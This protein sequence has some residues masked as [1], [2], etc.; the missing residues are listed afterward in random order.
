MP[1]R[2]YYFLLRWN[3]FYTVWLA[4]DCHLNGRYVYPWLYI[5]SIKTNQRVI[6]LGGWNRFLHTYIHTYT[7]TKEHTWN[8]QK[9][10]ESGYCIPYCPHYS[11]FRRMRLVCCWMSQALCVARNDVEPEPLWKEE[12]KQNETICISR[13]F[14]N[15]GVET[16]NN[17]YMIG[18]ARKTEM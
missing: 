10:H 1:A 7:Q 11:Q 6:Q 2:W 15:V 12:E 17:Y 18:T 4:D 3:S 13:F 9:I 5:T 16:W 14:A 8:W